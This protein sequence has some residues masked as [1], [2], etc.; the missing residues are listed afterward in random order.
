MRLR[1]I[2]GRTLC[3]AMAG[4]TAGG[5][6]GKRRKCNGVTITAEVQIIRAFANI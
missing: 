2:Q 6:E 5:G 3:A 1:E 4:L